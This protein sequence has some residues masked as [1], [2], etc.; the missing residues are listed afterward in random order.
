MGAALE[1]MAPLLLAST[2][3]CLSEACL[4]AA[5]MLRLRTPPIWAVLALNI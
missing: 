2:K 1:Y 4:L 3:S 5:V